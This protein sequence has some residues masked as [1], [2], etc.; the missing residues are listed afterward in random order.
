MVASQ[1]DD[2]RI[3]L[4]LQ[5]W[6]SFVCVGSWSALEDRVMPLFDLL[7]SP[8]IIVANSIRREG[9]LQ[10]SQ[11]THEVTGIS[12]Q[13]STVAQLSNGFASRGTL[14][15]PLNRTL[16]EPFLLVSLDFAEYVLEIEAARTLSNSA[17]PETS[18]WTVGSSRVKG[19]SYESNVVLCIL[20]CKARVVR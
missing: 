11:S 15:P 10:R 6:T 4:A 18:S 7:D 3:S 13:S 19:R 9:S 16:R 12:P 17:R 14:Y 8:C 2:S 20:V 1:G 5:R